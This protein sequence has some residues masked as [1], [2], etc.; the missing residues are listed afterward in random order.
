MGALVRDLLL[1]DLIGFQ[2]ANDLANFA[3]A[4]ELF[5]NAV[6]MAGNILNVAGRKVR[7]GVFPVEI[8]PHGFA[9]LAE[10][11]ALSTEDERLRASIAGQQMIMG[12]ERLDPT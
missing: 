11:M 4:A 3:A 10:K 12:V 8:E 5:G 7:L 6:R 9:N 1:A 2:T